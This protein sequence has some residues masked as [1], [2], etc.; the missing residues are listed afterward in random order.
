MANYA[1]KG[2]QEFWGTCTG[3]AT[4]ES[5]VRARNVG[6]AVESLAEACSD[7][8]PCYPLARTSVTP[9]ALGKHVDSWIYRWMHHGTETE[10]ARKGYPKHRSTRKKERQK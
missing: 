3:A 7:R 9:R 1:Y 8:I 6:S 4:I 10:G 2:R 5:E